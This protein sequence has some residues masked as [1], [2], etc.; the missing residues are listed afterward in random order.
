MAL[1]ARLNDA[2]PITAP[3]QVSAWRATSIGRDSVYPSSASQCTNSAVGRT[4]AMASR[5][6]TRTPRQSWLPM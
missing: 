2:M 3:I 4:P 6:L 5:S 1:R